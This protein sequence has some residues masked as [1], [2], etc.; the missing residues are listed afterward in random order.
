M[1][2]V[3]NDITQ[4]P[5]FFETGS[6]VLDIDQK[7]KKSLTYVSAVSPAERN[8]AELRI[9]ENAAIVAMVRDALTQ[10]SACY[11]SALGRLV[12]ASPYTQAVDIERAIARLNADIE[13]YRAPAPTWT[14]GPSLA[15]Q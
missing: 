1:D 2:D 7:R 11:R 10:R 6:R 8:N 12:I 14:R 15:I 5:Q 13:R 9:R 3:R 4:V